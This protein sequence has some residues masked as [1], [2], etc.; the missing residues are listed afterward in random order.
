[1]FTFKTPLKSALGFGILLIFFCFYFC[2]AISF[3]IPGVCQYL[4]PCPWLIISVERDFFSL[5]NK[6]STVYS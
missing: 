5:G 3:Q 1:M 2:G 6:W 4:S